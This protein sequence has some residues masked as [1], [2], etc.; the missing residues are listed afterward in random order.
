MTQGN[1]FISILC[2]SEKTFFLPL[3]LTLSGECVI[4]SVLSHHNKYL[5][6]RT[7][8]TAQ[9]QLRILFSKQST[10]YPQAWG[11]AD[12]KEKASICL[13]FHFL[14]ISSPLPWA[15]P[16]QIRASQKGGVFISPEALSGV[17]GFSFV[18]FSWAFPFDF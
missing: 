12:P 9:L 6:Q 16:M 5:R 15:S 14:Y 17:S 3:P 4:S 2:Y 18:P 11:W 7:S 10:V 1:Y 8:V 13:G